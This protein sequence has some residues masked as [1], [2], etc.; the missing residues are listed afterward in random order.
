VSSGRIAAAPPSRAWGRR[1]LFLALSGLSLTGCGIFGRDKPPP[2][3]LPVVVLRDAAELVRYRPGAGRDLTDVVDHTKFAR[4]GS[5]C[6]YSK[7][8]VDVDLALDIVVEQGPAASSREV[9][10]PYFVAIVDADQ[11]ILAKKVFETVI[12]LEQGHRRGGV[13]EET[14]Q[15]VPL[16]TVDDR[17]RYEI[18]IGFQLSHEQLEENRRRQQ[19]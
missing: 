4:F 1:L 13:R 3:C 19:R 14:E 10:V 5:K 6:D 2:P 18:M 16:A 17:R 15:I 12:E 8:R 7:D 11:H 9:H